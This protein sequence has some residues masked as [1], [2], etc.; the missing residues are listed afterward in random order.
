MLIKTQFAVRHLPSFDVHGNS[1]STR[2][3]LPLVSINTSFIFL[4]DD[5]VSSVLKLGTYRRGPSHYS[6]GI[7]VECRSLRI[8][9]S[10]WREYLSAWRIL[11]RRRLPN[12]SA[13]KSEQPDNLINAARNKFV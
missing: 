11:P 6:V 5:E 2:S 8:S 13:T 10:L 4:A 9:F 12:C 3:Y 7:C 1:F